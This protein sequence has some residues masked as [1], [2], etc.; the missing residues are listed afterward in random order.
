MIFR[1]SFCALLAVLSLDAAAVRAAEPEFRSSIVTEARIYARTET[2]FRIAGIPAGATTTDVSRVTVAVA[3]LL[4]TGEWEP[5]T[6]R[7]PS[8]KDFRRG[9]DVYAAIERNRLLLKLPD[10]DVVTAKI[11]NREKQKSAA[12]ER[13]GHD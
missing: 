2:S 12:F 3:G 4:V 5:K 7:S 6:V 10:G 9:S 1:Y 11:V 8:A 13:R